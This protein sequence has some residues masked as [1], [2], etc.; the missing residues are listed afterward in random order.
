MF[1]ISSTGPAQQVD[2]KHFNATAV[3]RDLDQTAGASVTPIG[4]AWWDSHVT[5]S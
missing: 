3:F 5:D 2:S 4:P 1:G